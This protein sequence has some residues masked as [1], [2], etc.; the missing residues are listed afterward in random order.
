MLAE[1]VYNRRIIPTAEL[2]EMRLRISEAAGNVMP[3][4]FVMIDCAGSTSLRRPISIADSDNEFIRI[5]Y[6]VRGNGT[7]NMS[8]MA[9][10]SSVDVLAPLGHGFTCY[11]GKKALLIGGGIGIYPLLP[12]ARFYGGN[13][14]ALFG[15]RSASIINFT[16]EF[17]ACGSGC[18]VI[19][20]DGSSG[21]KGFVTELAEEHL[22][23][24]GFD[25]I[26]VCGPKPMMAAVA[27]LA[28]R[29]NVKCE[30]S[31]EERMACGIGAC[32]GCVCKTMFKSNEGVTGEKYKR[33]CKDGPVFDAEEIIW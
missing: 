28:S 7:E 8:R 23:E 24:G 30:V 13:A 10:G 19:T 4:Q 2:Y 31:M 27:K 33:V 32:Y 25:I 18:E 1:I 11:E 15:F 21:R 17:I 3:G 20:D 14:Q 26:Y 5:C 16:D 9:E 22:A 12:L 6:D 29:Y